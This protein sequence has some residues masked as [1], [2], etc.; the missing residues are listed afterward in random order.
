M[1]QK[2]IL[3]NPILFSSFSFL[4]DSFSGHGN[5]ALS[6]KDKDHDTAAAHSCAKSYQGG[7]W[8]DACHSCNLNGLY[9][10]GPSGVARA[11]PG[12]RLAHPE[13]QNEE[14]NK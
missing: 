6:T 11:F 12:G 10:R 13:N 2:T 3:Q 9:L 5:L 14:E 7:W 8:Y 1:L 4:G